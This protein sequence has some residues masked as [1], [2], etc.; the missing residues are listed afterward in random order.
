MYTFKHVCVE[1][2]NQRGYISDILTNVDR[3]INVYIYIIHKL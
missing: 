2:D 1:K 3:W